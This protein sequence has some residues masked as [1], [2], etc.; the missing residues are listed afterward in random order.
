MSRGLGRI[1]RECLRVIE[2]YAQMGERPTTFTIAAEVYNV[3]PDRHGDR[4]VN[5]AQ[6]SATK[7]ALIG[8][9]RMG[10]VAGEQDTEVHDGQRMLAKVRP[11]TSRAERCCFWTIVKGSATTIVFR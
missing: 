11:G 9:R 7:R 1:Q 3:R 6:H 10:L 8:L 4:W 5:D 2:E